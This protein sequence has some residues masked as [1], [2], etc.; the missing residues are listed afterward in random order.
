MYNL[1]RK[2]KK[3]LARQVYAVTGDNQAKVDEFRAV[4]V[5]L[6]DMKK[7][8]FQLFRAY[9]Y[10]YILIVYFKLCGQSCCVLLKK[11][12]VSEGLEDIWKTIEKFRML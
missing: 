12:R 11:Q 10:M 5:F 8:P 7:N 9:L 6:V 2:H 1:G 3:H 4:A